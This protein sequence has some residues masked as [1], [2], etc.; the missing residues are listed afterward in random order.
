MY[1]RVKFD[2]IDSPKT[3]NTI[4]TLTGSPSGL[5][6]DASNTMLVAATKSRSTICWYF[7]V[8]VI[9]KYYGGVQNMLNGFTSLP[10]VSSVEVLPLEGDPHKVPVD[11]LQVIR[12]VLLSY[13]MT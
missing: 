8:D 1:I 12:E 7:D 2:D 5:W 3:Q 11:S 6:T 9:N 4:Q 13:A 10:G